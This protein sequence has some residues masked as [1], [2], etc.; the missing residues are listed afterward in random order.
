[1]RFECSN[2]SDFRIEVDGV[3]YAARGIELSTLPAS[4]LL[5]K[6]SD[7][8]TQQQWVTQVKLTPSTDYNQQVNI[9]SPSPP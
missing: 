7:T 2:P 3:V 1:M 6:A 8:T 5:I 4:P 9:P